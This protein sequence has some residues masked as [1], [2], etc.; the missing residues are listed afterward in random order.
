MNGMPYSV[1]FAVVAV[2]MWV[3]TQV[4]KA[5]LSIME[6][7]KA[8][9]NGTDVRALH[10]EVLATQLAVHVVPVLAKQLEVLAK[11]ETVADRQLEAAV[12]HKFKLGEMS[13]QLARTHGNVHEMANR[14]QELSNRVQELLILLPKRGSD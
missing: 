8:N 13:A 6:K 1:D 11:L 4:V 12:E 3:F 9:G 14:V 10:S 2:A 7:S 5:S